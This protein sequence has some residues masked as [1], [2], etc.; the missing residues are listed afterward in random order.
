MPDYSCLVQLDTLSNKSIYILQSKFQTRLTNG[1]FQITI[2][3]RL[4][5][6]RNVS[7][8]P[9]GNFSLKRLKLFQ[10]TLVLFVPVSLNMAFKLKYKNK[11]LKDL[12]ETLNK[13]TACSD[14]L[15][16]SMAL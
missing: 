1:V 12:S 5:S 9:S 11:N 14:L 6:E 10:T 3:N 13:T 15:W 7:I 16:D 4:L 2:V 8:T